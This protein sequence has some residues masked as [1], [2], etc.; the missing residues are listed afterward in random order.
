MSN[1]KCK[2]KQ[3]GDQMV[4][5]KCQETWDVN[6]WEPPECNKDKETFVANADDFYEAFK[7]ALKWLGPGWSEKE[8]VTVS[9][10]DGKFVMTYERVAVSMDLNA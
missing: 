10:H 8:K 3:Y 6:D 4:C 7:D 9:I 5:H 1:D 2:A